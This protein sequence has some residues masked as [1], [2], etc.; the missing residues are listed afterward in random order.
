V[1]GV[2]AKKGSGRTFAERKA[3]LRDGRQSSSFAPREKAPVILSRSERRLNGPIANR[4]LSLGES[5]IRL[6]F[7][8][9]K[10]DCLRRLPIVVFRSAKVGFGCPFAERKA[11]LRGGRQSSSFEERKATF[12]SSRSDLLPSRRNREDSVARH[13]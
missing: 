10:G 5:R 4:R 3:T 7:R 11:T 12:Q 13:K 2:D 8:G 9:A 1:V 6:A